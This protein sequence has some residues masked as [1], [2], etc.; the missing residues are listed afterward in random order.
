MKLLYAAQSRGARSRNKSKTG[1]PGVELF[2]AAALL[3][4]VKGE[5]QCLSQGSCFYADWGMPCSDTQEDAA[6]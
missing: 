5:I 3:T 2:I 1:G 4:Q 6:V